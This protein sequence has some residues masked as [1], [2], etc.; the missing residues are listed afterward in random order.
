MDKLNVPYFAERLAQVL[1]CDATLFRKELFSPIHILRSLPLS[2]PPTVFTRMKS[3]FSTTALAALL[4]LATCA[5]ACSCIEI[6]FTDVASRIN[7]ADEHDAAM[8]VGQVT[9]IE[10]GNDWFNTY[11]FNV[12]EVFKSPNAS[13]HLAVVANAQVKVKSGNNSA[14]CGMNFNWGETWLMGVHGSD[15]SA[16]LSAGSC[17]FL[18]CRLSPQE[19]GNVYHNCTSRLA[20]LRGGNGP[21][22]AP[23][24]PVPTT[25]RSGAAEIAISLA[26]SIAV[27]AC[28][29]VW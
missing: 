26:V 21:R 4:L 6:G 29:L 15:N 7:Y 5:S 11:T 27:M 18:T 17:N 2:L 9:K 12:S 28:A 19:S 22:T 20:Y 16:M 3:L 24:T 1:Q 14:M 10:A 23:P 13:S 8:F 25:G